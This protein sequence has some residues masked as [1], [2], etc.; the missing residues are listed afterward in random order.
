MADSALVTLLFLEGSGPR[1]VAEIAAEL[2]LS[3]NAARRIVETLHARGFVVRDAA[4]RLRLG[5]ALLT[6][7][8]DLPTELAIAAQPHVVELADRLGETV[9]LAML[10]GEH[11][12]IVTQGLGAASPLRVE[13]EIGFRQSLS[14]GASS[15]AILAHLPPEDE[16]VARSGV[17]AAALAEIRARGYARTEGDIRAGM[18]GIAAPLYRQSASIAGSLAIIAPTTRAGILSEHAELLRSTADLI[19]NAY[20]SLRASGRVS[21]ETPR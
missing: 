21:E 9:V 16:R 8:A 12:V 15:L 7:A 4:Q 13:H 6:V 18:V 14:R 10:E 3:S 19:R 17:P 20:R 11:S 5:P 2:G 1:T